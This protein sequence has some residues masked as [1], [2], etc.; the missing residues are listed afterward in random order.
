MITAGIHNSSL[1]C[2]IFIL[3]W[4][5]TVGQVLPLG[6]SLHF[7]CLVQVFDILSIAWLEYRW[8]EVLLVVL[9]NCKNK[10][11]GNWS[12][13]RQG[14]YLCTA[15]L[16]E[17]GI[18]NS[19]IGVIER[20]KSTGAEIITRWKLITWRRIVAPSFPISPSYSISRQASLAAPVVRGML[21]SRW[22]FRSLSAASQAWHGLWRNQPL[23]RLSARACKSTAL[24]SP[25]SS[26]IW[27]F[28]PLTWLL[29]F[30]RPNNR[31]LLFPLFS[32]SNHE[33]RTR[34]GKG[35]TP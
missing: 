5:H 3:F 27:H 9:R 26:G 1:L 7:L 2:N 6:R 23:L 8:L 10:L 17:A 22:G 19:A 34:H 14:K 35:I 21:I 15:G 12:G 29:R 16:W 33:S 28:T 31:N 18:A 30:H 24:P 32:P 13:S 25:L 4:G 11:I 20:E